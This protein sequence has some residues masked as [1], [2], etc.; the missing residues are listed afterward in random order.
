[1]LFSFA[2][3]ITIIGFKNSPIIRTGI[4]LVLTHWYLIAP[5][6]LYVAVRVYAK[7]KGND[8]FKNNILIGILILSVWY[9]IFDAWASYDT[10]V[11]DHK[12][13]HV[14]LRMK[15]KS[16]RNTNKTDIFLGRTKEYWFFYNPKSKYTR[17]IKNDEI[18][19][20]DFDS[21]LN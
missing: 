9:G 4:T 19:T 7:S 3:T 8:I 18:E 2:L 12:Q 15:D 1:M 11:E 20:V 14:I 10:I 13:S 21:L 5:L 17:V 16:I 6:I